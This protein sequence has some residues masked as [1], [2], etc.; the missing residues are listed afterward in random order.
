MPLRPGVKYVDWPVDDPGGQDEATVRRIIADIDSRVRDLLVSVPDIDLPR[1]CS[2]RSSV[3][4]MCGQVCSG[5]PAKPC[6]VPAYDCCD[7]EDAAN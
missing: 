3:T 2:T 1:R 4:D 7:G 6:R 5:Q